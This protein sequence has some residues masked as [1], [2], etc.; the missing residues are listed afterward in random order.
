[1]DKQLLADILA[2]QEAESRRRL[3]HQPQ[4]PNP[5]MDRIGDRVNNWWS[6]VVDRT[7]DIA[8][9]FTDPS[10]A[11]RE[12]GQLFDPAYMNTIEPPDFNQGLELAANFLPG[13]A[14]GTKGKKPSG[15][16]QEWEEE[17]A[18]R[19]AQALEQVERS[20]FALS[21]AERVEQRRQML[22]SLPLGD[23]AIM[24]NIAPDSPL[25]EEEFRALQSAAVER[26]RAETV[27]LLEK[28]QAAQPYETMPRS[29]LIRLQREAHG[30]MATSTPGTPEHEA[31][32][33]AFN[34]VSAALRRPLSHAE[35]QME[36]STWGRRPST[37]S[38]EGRPSSQFGT[39]D[40]QARVEALFKGIAE[41]PANFQFGGK[42]PESTELADIV[43]HYSRPKNPIRLGEF[44]DT[45][46]PY[47]NVIKNPTTGGALSV[48][49]METPT[50]HVS[51]ADA[52]SQGRQQGGG[53]NMY[54]AVMSWIANTGKRLR[55]DPR[56]IST[57]NKLRKVSNTI[58][59]YLRHGKEGYIDLSDATTAR[60]LKELIV[61][62][63]DKVLGWRTDLEE[64]AQFDGE[65]F[66][67]PSGDVLSDG[68]LT[69]LIE[70]KDPYFRMGIGVSTL[71]RALMTKWAMSATQEEV[72]AAAKKFKDPVLYSLAGLTV[73]N[74]GEKIGH[75]LVPEQD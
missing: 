1:M 20:P 41:D 57:V 33:A 24:R 54:Q 37:P 22:E 26:E 8:G 4:T 49:D 42:P 64:A 2:A 73:A 14:L 7:G 45:I 10:R 66:V 53:T 19:L 3:T 58:S 62:E 23:Q 71:K 65:R 9:Y 70:D 48:Y 46:L 15:L 35:I 34:E 5:Y 18:A 59:N 6:G 72:K 30:R 38:L 31:A 13:G 56:G 55:P 43:A 51:S 50:P 36:E 25:W 12:I 39:P 61:N 47:D 16:K 29:I 75:L 69:R 17:E 32:Q 60:N 40:E 63:K 67:S 44:D 52:T 11:G 68:Y 74:E 28:E 27:R 21:A